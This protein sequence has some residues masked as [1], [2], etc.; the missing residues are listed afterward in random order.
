MEEK[1]LRILKIDPQFKN[2]IRP[3][4]KREYLQL[5]ENLLTDGCRDPLIVWNGFLVD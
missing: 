4:R 2:L 1:S 3:L 5:E